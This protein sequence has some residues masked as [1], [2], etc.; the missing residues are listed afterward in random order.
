MQ[1]VIGWTV[2]VIGALICAAGI[3]FIAI[4]AIIWF[5]T[6]RVPTIGGDLFWMA[7]PL[8]VITAIGG[9]FIALFGA[10]LVNGSEPPE[11]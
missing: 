8:S 3:C 10:G 11:G 4:E 7:L 6:G 2:I 9:V 1:T 5:E